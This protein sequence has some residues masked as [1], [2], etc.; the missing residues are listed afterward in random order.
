MSKIDE[1][2]FSNGQTMVKFGK[3]FTISEF[4]FG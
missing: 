3:T 4:L 2:I 1:I